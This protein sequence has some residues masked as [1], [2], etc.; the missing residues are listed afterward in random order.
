MLQI[1][2][3]ASAIRE[4]QRLRQTEVGRRSGLS[5]TTISRIEVGDIASPSADTVVRLA[6]GLGVEPGELFKNPEEPFRTLKGQ[7]YSPLGQPVLIS[8]VGEGEGAG[9][10]SPS[11]N[12]AL[13]QLRALTSD[14]ERGRLGDE[15]LVEGVGRVHERLRALVA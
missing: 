1:G 3:R 6:K 4:A 15:A 14:W 12:D 10:A 2:K 8:A 5:Q 13:A 7:T 9:F 11:M